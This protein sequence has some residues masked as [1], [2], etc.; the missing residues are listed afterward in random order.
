[1]STI[2]TTLFLFA[3]RTL[4][5]LV[6]TSLLGL[7]GCLVSSDTHTS[8]SGKYVSD[9]TWRQID[10]GETSAAWVEATLGEPSERKRMDDGTEIWRWNY[11]EHKNSS[12]HIFLLFNGSSS[13]EKQSA[14]IIELKDGVVVKKW[15]A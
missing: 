5:L 12:G 13:K 14:A 3:R 15:R 11:T 9:R 8:Q 10:E 6:M 4:A 2:L 1:M 7:S